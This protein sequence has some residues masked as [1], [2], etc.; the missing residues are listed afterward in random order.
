MAEKDPALHGTQIA[1]VVAPAIRQLRRNSM[2]CTKIIQNQITNTYAYAYAYGDT[3]TDIHKYT[4]IEAT[5][6]LVVS[7]PESSGSTFN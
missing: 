5:V 6:K 1:A 3:D 2:K 7:A 4:K